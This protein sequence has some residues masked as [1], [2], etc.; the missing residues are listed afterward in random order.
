MGSYCKQAIYQS[1]QICQRWIR[2]DRAHLIAPAR[3]LRSNARAHD[4]KVRAYGFA[5]IRRLVARADYAAATRRLSELR[6]LDDLFHARLLTGQTRHRQHTHVRARL[7]CGD[8]RAIVAECNFAALGE[9][10]A[11][12]LESRLEN[13]LKPTQREMLPIAIRRPVAGTKQM[14]LK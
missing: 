8:R 9:L 6:Q 12:L 10:A 5:H 7:A 3:T 11:E 1:W 2:R 4:P 14:S 13:P